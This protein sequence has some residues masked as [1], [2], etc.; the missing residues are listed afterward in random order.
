MTRHLR[1]SGQFILSVGAFAAVILSFTAAAFLA[2]PDAQFVYVII[3]FLVFFA[4]LFI[5]LSLI[6]HPLIERDGIT[7]YLDGVQKKVTAWAFKEEDLK[8]LRRLEKRL[9]KKK[10]HSR[11]PTLAARVS[12]LIT[13]MERLEKARASFYWD[14]REGTTH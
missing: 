10:G 5:P 13:E 4:A 3:L 7:A 9:F 6:A 11:F 1:I 14:E 8:N 2:G 12:F